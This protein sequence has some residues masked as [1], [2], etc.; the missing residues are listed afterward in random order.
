MTLM[1]TIRNAALAALLSALPL[2]TAQAQAL[3]APSGDVILTVSGEIG[4]TNAEDGAAF[5]LADLDQL[6]QTGFETTTIWTEGVQ[7]FSGVRLSDMLARVGAEGGSLLMTAL[8]DYQ[9]EVDAG[10]P[11]LKDALLAT[12]QNGAP[13]S[14]RDHGPVWLVFPYDA[15]A[16]LRSEIVYSKSIWQLTRIEV[17]N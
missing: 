6:P 3:P 10:D 4:V 12:R 7:S 16:N 1:N 14:V 11:F 8:N 2:H 9:I 5:G 15:D 13:M 17:R